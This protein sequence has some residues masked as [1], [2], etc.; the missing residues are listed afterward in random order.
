MVLTSAD[1]VLYCS[2]VVLRGSRP[3]DTVYR[4]EELRASG[5]ERSAKDFAL[6]VTPYVFVLLYLGILNVNRLASCVHCT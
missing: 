3:R 4:H 5:L 6:T 1:F 2:H